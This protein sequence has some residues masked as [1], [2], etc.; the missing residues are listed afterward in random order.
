[1]KLA[2]LLLFLFS[3]FILS[4]LFAHAQRADYSIEQFHADLTIRDDGFVEIVEKIEGEFFVEKHGL[5]RELPTRFAIDESTQV[6]IDLAV[7]KVTDADGNRIDFE[8]FIYGDRIDLRI[9]DPDVALSGPYTYI[10]SYSAS[11]VLL[12]F[13]DHD[14]LFWNVTGTGWE[15]PIEHSSAEVFLPNSVEVLDTA[16]YTGAYGTEEKNCEVSE[17]D[18][19]LRI[20][21]VGNLTVAVGFTPGVVEV[22]RPEIIT[23]SELEQARA[24]ELAASIARKERLQALAT[25]FL[26]IPLLVG[27]F[28]I[29][30]WRLHGKDMKK[31]G[32]IIARYSP[33]KDLRPTELATVLDNTTH[34]RDLS[35]ALVDLAV[36][37][38]LHIEEHEKKA[39]TKFTL[40]KEKPA[41]A[42]LNQW[43]QTLLDTLFEK[44]DTATSQTIGT[45][46]AKKRHEIGQLVATKLH[47]EG[48]YSQKLG[49]RKQGMLALGIILFAFGVPL[50]VF[51]GDIMHSAVPII[52]F[53]LSSVV[54][55]VAVPFMDQRTEKGVDAKAHAKGF[56]LFLEKAEKYRIKWQEKEGLFEEYLPYAMALGVA[57]KWSRAFAKL[58]EEE[59]RTMQ[60]PNWYTGSGLATFNPVSLTHH[61]TTFSEAIQ[62]VSSS[63]SYRGPSSSGLSGGSSGGGGFSGGGFG[64]GGGRSW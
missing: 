47:E 7:E 8:P 30:R 21:G 22:V 40:H 45:R 4:P 31:I 13:E 5:F 44:A 25:L 60:N 39:K 3:L 35:A 49:R 20:S 57:D 48:Y 27:F 17:E 38:Y 59:G 51:F 15:V 64:G 1:M 26:A 10:I 28:V 6:I 12:Y 16:C 55:F 36:R 58:Y 24:Q 41:D 11:G 37:G 54:C 23:L 34:T 2:P 14:E 9:G 18:D 33:P 50:G 19:R 52:S 56:K 61:L 29:S 43:E 62:P 32:T 46:L 42:E 53:V 63:T